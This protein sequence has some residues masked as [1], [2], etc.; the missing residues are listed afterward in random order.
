MGHLSFP[1]IFA[2]YVG[3]LIIPY[4]ING[5]FT[6]PILSCYSLH[7]TSPFTKGCIHSHGAPFLPVSSFNN[8][9]W[10]HGAPILPIVT[11][12]A[13]IYPTFSTHG[14]LDYS[15]D[16]PYL[17]LVHSLKSQFLFYLFTRIFFISIRFCS[18]SLHHVFSRLIFNPILYGALSLPICIVFH[19]F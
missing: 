19:L 18:F 2:A 5:A 13:L 10:T 8:F 15:S 6:H 7:I 3:A 4:I 14:H 11:F 16:C 1:Y 17:S 12:A 9:F